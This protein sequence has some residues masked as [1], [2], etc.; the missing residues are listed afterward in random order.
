MDKR[1]KA[2]RRHPPGLCRYCRKNI[3]W[4]INSTSG[5][6]TDDDINDNVLAS[7]CSESPT[8]GHVLEGKEP[9]Q[10]SAYR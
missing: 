4:T 5:Y 10:Q 8:Y 3:S 9:R 2:L 6:Y 7:E 1:A